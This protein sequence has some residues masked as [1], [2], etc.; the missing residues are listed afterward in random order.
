[1]IDAVTTLTSSGGMP[2]IFIHGAPIF[3]TPNRNDEKNIP[4]GEF[5]ANKLT[6]IPSKPTAK[7]DPC[8]KHFQRFLDLQLLLQDLQELQR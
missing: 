4:S 8:T 2:A 7:E 1:M 5:A 3:K 6:A